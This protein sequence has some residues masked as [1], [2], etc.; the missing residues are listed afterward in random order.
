MMISN[1]VMSVQGAVGGIQPRRSQNEITHKQQP[2]FLLII[3]VDV[4]MKR[5]SAVSVVP[6]QPSLASN[7]GGSNVGLA[8]RFNT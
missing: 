3:Q 1:R 8:S 7:P 6:L 4:C 5:P 2:G